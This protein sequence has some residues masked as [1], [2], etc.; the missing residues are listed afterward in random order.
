LPAFADS[1]GA[2]ELE[3]ELDEGVFSMSLRHPILA[4]ILDDPSRIPGN[5]DILEIIQTPIYLH[6][7]D[8]PKTEGE[9]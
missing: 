3:M 7:F 2:I 6:G 8:A 5:A 1:S 4:M 9:S